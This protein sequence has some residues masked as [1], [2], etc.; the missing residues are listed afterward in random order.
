MDDRHFDKESAQEWIQTIEGEK[1]RVREVDLY[2]HLQEWIRRAA[3]AAV[4]DI[5]CGQGICSEKL[6]FNVRQYVGV[7]AS[8]FLIERARQLYPEPQKHFLTANLYALPFSNE[9]FAAV[10]SIAV[11]HLLADKEKAARELARVLAN[12][13][14][15]LIVAANPDRYDDWLSTYSSVERTGARADGKTLRPDG[16]QSVD[17]LYLHSQD[18][19]IRS[20]RAARLEVQETKTFRLAI[21]FQG[22]KQSL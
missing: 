7:D 4:L 11:W 17:T 18:E 21:S 3:P 10:F 9:N 1:S 6:A 12:G 14:H 2:P 13:G 8:P 15:F 20:L 5:G 22:K 19:I 16:S